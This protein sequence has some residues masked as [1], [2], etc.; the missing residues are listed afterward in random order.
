MAG[1]FFSCANDLEKVQKITMSPN[2]PDETSEDFNV[3][4]TDSGYAT[5][6][7]F[8][9]IAESYTSP[10][11]NTK[12]KDGLK[13]LFYDESGKVS[14]E[15]TSVYGEIDEESGNIVVRDSVEF[16]NKQTMELLKTEVLYWNKK[17]DSI[18]TNK[19]VVLS[20]PDKVIT[21]IGA[22]TNHTMDTLIVYKPQAIIYTKN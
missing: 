22:R 8:A 3:I 18:Y 9:K 14:S 15:L 13:V 21:G 16:L 19:P 6:Q 12:F 2:S 10:K 5:F 20:S 4:V 7:L 17:A 11:K 1:I